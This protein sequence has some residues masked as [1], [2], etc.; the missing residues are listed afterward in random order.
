MGM[1][2][3]SRTRKPKARTAELLVEELGEEVLVYDQ[4]DD[5]VHCLGSA[6]H[7]VWSACDGETPVEQL[8]RRLNLD[9][10]LVARALGELEA[11]GLLDDEATGGLTRRE[12][13]GRLAKVGAAAAA[14]PLIYSIAAP[15]PAAAAT[16]LTCLNTGSCNASLTTAK[17]G[18]TPGCVLCAVTGGTSNPS[19]NSCVPSDCSACTGA[20]LA[21]KCATVCGGGTKYTCPG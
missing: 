6:A 16:L 15:A 7:R 14:A 8:G 9:S 3:G 21:A 12:A 10:E 4:R 5:R 20:T 11:C 1:L 19:C 13:T 18:A 17:C 2:R